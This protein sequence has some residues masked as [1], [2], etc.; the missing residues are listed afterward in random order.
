VLAK[1]YDRGRKMSFSPEAAR[2]EKI[3]RLEVIRAD[4][5]AEIKQ[6]IQQRD[7]YI[8]EMSIGLAAIIGL[9]ASQRMP[10]LV[11]LAPMVSLYYSYLLSESY[12]IHKNQTRYLRDEIGRR[13]MELCEM[14]PE[15]EWE[16]WYKNQAKLE[17]GLR[18]TFF[19]TCLCLVWIAAPGFVYGVHRL[20]GTTKLPVWTIYAAFALYTLPTIYLLLNFS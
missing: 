1:S 11:L 9:A 10:D 20:L 17:P 15:V 12:K 3:K 4:V 18:K 8:I 2:S 16:N 13:L 5:R 6:R 7:Q 14:E 19:K